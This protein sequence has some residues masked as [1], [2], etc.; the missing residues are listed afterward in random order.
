MNCNKHIKSRSQFS[1]YYIN[2][3]LVLFLKSSFALAAKSNKFTLEAN[4]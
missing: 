1:P 3:F 2:I 4:S